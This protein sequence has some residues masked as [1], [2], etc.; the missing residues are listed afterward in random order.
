MADERRGWILGFK[1]DNPEVWKK[2]KDGEQLELSI[3]GKGERVEVELTV[4]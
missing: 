1:V 3:G 2:I 4:V